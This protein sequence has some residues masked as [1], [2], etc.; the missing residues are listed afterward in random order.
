[1]K[2]IFKITLTAVLIFSIGYQITDADALRPRA[3]IE[4]E[5]FNRIPHTDDVGEF[6]RHVEGWV[7]AVEM[8]EHFGFQEL[9]KN[10]TGCILPGL[11]VS[12]DR[13]S[14]FGN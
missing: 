7:K 13:I 3:V 5:N 14:Q 8:H 4:R 12:P 11:R 10:G 2:N 9:L 6:K 1:M